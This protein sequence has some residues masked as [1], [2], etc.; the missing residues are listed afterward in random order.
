[1]DRQED[2]IY[3]NTI[4][5]NTNGFV[6]PCSVLDVRDRDIINRADDFEMSIIR[7][8]IPTQLLPLLI[9][10]NAINIYS[11]TLTCNG[12]NYQQFVPY[13]Q[14]SYRNLYGKGTLA[15][16]DYQT[17]LDDLNTASALAFADLLFNNPTC[18]ATQPPRWYY[19]ANTSLI[20]CYFDRGYIDGTVNGVEMWMNTI[21]F[22][23]LQAFTV[24]FFPTPQPLG[25]EIRFKILDSNTLAINNV[26]PRVNVPNAIASI[27]VTLLQ[28]QQSFICLGNFNS[29]RSIVITTGQL[30]VMYEY[31][32]NVVS[33]LQNQNVSN[34]NRAIVSDFEIPS[35]LDENTFRTSITYL[36]TAEYRMI[37]LLGNQSINKVDFQ[38]LFS[39]TNGIFYPLYL[40]IDRTV[41]IKVLFR[42]KKNLLV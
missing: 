1:M 25:K 9:V 42:R 22:N 23:L 34:N 15:Y 37:S 8:T 19:N 14:T 6:I 11:V 2:H 24:E 32:P 13:T 4:L 16:Y 7:F 26:I 38:I 33:N 40:D 17:F 18:V 31:L 10:P 29:V 35:I 28:L 21:L 39:D 5:H 27:N 12:N 3:F 20:S 36:P 30:P 41:S